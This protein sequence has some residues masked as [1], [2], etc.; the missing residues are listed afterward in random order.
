M[1]FFRRPS[2]AAHRAGGRRL[3]NTW[4]SNPPPGRTLSGGSRALTGMQM[5]SAIGPRPGQPRRRRPGGSLALVTNR[6]RQPQRSNWR[7]KLARASACLRWAGLAH[8]ARDGDV[9]GL[10]IKPSPAALARLFS[11]MR[12]LGTTLWCRVSFFGPAVMGR[13]LPLCSLGRQ[14][15]GPTSPLLPGGPKGRKSPTERRGPCTGPRFARQCRATTGKARPDALAGPAWRPSMT[16]HGESAFGC[17]GPPSRTGLFIKGH[18]VGGGPML[19]GAG[20]DPRFTL[21]A[22]HPNGH[23]GGGHLGES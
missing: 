5:N 2:V 19:I 13:V 16:A 12:R 21:T 4:A 3:Y 23:R 9:F 10:P 15:G 8:A 7:A 11:G 18:L 20:G 1:R 17:V 22:P 14:P 6:L